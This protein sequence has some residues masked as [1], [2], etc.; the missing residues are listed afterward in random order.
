MDDSDGGPSRNNYL[1]QSQIEDVFYCQ[2]I[3]QLAADELN[4]IFAIRVI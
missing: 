1:D 4:E 2:Q 3:S